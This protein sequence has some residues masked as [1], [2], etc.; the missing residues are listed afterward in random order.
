MLRTKN[1]ILLIAA[2]GLFAVFTAIPASQAQAPGDAQLAA[3]KTYCAGCHSE[4]AKTG[5][6]GPSPVAAIE[7]PPPPDLDFSNKK[8]T[9]FPLCSSLGETPK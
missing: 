5:G 9:M 7:R 8:G 3:I 6:L 2:I 1:S 4:K